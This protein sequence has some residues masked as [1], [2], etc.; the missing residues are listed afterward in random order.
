MV[1][2]EKNISYTNLVFNS[3]I[4]KM[5]LR[6]LRTSQSQ[7]YFGLGKDIE[8]VS[9]SEIENLFDTDTSIWL[10]NTLQGD[11]QLISTDFSTIIIHFISQVAEVRQIYL[12][13]ESES[14]VHIWS[15][16]SEKK[17]D[18]KKHIYEQER[19]LIQYF[20][21]NLYFDF[22][23]ALLSEIEYLKNSGALLIF[24]KK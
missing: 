14:V 1:E 24:E 16:V 5:P 9:K 10:K 21:E 18:I 3:F 23:V 2:L 22:H 6:I 11:F 19:N 13:R 7:S 4:S 15:I 20:K 8:T 17:E 12:M